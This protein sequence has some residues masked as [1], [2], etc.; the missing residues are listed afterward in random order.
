MIR[1]GHVHDMLYRWVF[2]RPFREAED[3]PFRGPTPHERERHPMGLE[4]ARQTTGQSSNAP[5]ARNLD[6]ILDP[7]SFFWARIGNSYSARRDLALT[8]DMI[9]G[10]LLRYVDA[11]ETKTWM[12]L[13]IAL[14]INVV[15]IQIELSL[16]QS[17]ME[18]EQQE[19]GDNSTTALAPGIT[20]YLRGTG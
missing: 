16:F 14:F 6:P 11:E 3:R 20:R 4:H 1:R 10:P 18:Q 5:T 13:I 15:C 8:Y 2:G 19:R 7:D 9:Y 12:W 17:I